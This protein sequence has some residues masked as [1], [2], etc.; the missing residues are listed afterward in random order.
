M[1]PC[2][3][4]GVNWGGMAIAQLPESLGD[5][6]IGLRGLWLNNNRLVALPESFGRMEIEGK[7]YQQRLTRT[8]VDLILNQDY[9]RFPLTIQI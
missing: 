8:K 2:S 1:P 3:F 4:R 9:R 5:I 6:R 7:Q